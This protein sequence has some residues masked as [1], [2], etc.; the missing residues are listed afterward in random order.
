MFVSPAES[1]V[2]LVFASVVNRSFCCPPVVEPPVA[3]NIKNIHRKCC[4]TQQTSLLAH[5]AVPEMLITSVS[6]LKVI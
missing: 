1:P 5:R 3:G 2:V 6:P 4:D